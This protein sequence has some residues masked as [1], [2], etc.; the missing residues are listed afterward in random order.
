AGL[1]KTDPDWARLP[2]DTP[3]PVR[4]LLR[5]CLQKDRKQRLHCIGDATLELADA[6]KP[7]A[8]DVVAT[9]AAV[10]SRRERAA[11]IALL[12]AV[13]VLAGVSLKGLRS[14]S[15]QR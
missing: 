7:S 3:A 9:D 11:W 8:A 5:R 4:R 15:P 2:V 13:L 12:L 14:P 6:A 1:I 10:P